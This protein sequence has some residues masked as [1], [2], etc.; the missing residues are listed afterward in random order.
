MSAI[1]WSVI[2]AS[3]LVFALKFAGYLVP[4]KVVA[5]PVVSRVAGVV[6]I[7]LLSSLV[8]SQTLAG[9]GGIVLD[10]RIPAVAVA[11]LLLWF[12]APF[13][14]VIVAAALVAAGLRLI[15]WMP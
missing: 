13:I 14:V 1:W 9:D 7:A 15:G 10:A 5:G 11:G 2:A 3:L 6:T 4:Q 12:R 8:A